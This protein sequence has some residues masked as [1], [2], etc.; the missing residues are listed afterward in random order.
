MLATTAAMGRMMFLRIGMLCG[1][2]MEK[3]E[4]VGKGTKCRCRKS[5]V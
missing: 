5:V 1:M 4:V 2:L 3:G